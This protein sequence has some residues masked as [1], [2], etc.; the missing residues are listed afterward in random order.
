MNPED[1][2]IDHPALDSFAVTVEPSEAVHCFVAESYFTVTIRP[3]LSAVCSLGTA[4]TVRVTSPT[5]VT[6]PFLRISATL[7]IKS[8][9]EE[10][11]FHVRVNS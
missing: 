11:A 7:S 3:C 8:A 5:A 2:A 9:A 4:V 1:V 6:A 10:V